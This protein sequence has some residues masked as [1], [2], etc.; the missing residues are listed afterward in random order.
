MVTFIDRVAG[1]R[2]EVTGNEEQNKNLFIDFCVEVLEFDVDTVRTM[3]R[4]LHA[5]KANQIESIM[6]ESCDGKLFDTEEVFMNNDVG[7]VPS[8]CGDCWHFGDDYCFHYDS[9][10]R[11]RCTDAETCGHFNC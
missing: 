1:K 11:A 8:V 10:C 6:K 9:R 4:W 3:L 5:P 2:Y 7:D